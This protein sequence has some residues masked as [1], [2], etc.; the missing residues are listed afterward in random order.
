MPSITSAVFPDIVAGADG[1][2]AIAYLGTTQS[3]DGWQDG[4]SSYASDDTVWHLYVAYLDD[5]TAADPL[6]VTARITPDLD[7]VQRGC[8]WMHGGLNPCRNLRDFMDMVEHDGQVYVVY[9][10]GCDKC[11]SASE[12]HVLDETTVVI[13]ESG[14]RLRDE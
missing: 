5:A 13:Q 11:A 3:D 1:R 9:P 4:D 10:D 8:I 2:I 14:S 7:P 12:S 6:V